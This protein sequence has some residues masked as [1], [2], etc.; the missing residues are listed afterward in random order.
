MSL[1]GQTPPVAAQAEAEEKQEHQKGVLAPD[2]WPDI[3]SIE[4]ETEA[5]EEEEWGPPSPDMLPDIGPITIE[6]DEPLDNF[7]VE[8]QQRLLTEPLYSSWSGPEDG[9]PFLVAANVGVFMSVFEPPVAPDVLL[10]MDVETPT[11]FA[12]KRNRTYFGWEFGKPPEVVIDIVTNCE[13]HAIEQKIQRYAWMK[14]DYA[15]VYDPFLCLQGDV[16]S[17]YEYV[18]LSYTRIE[19]TWLISA[20]LGLTLWNGVFEGI[21]GTWL[22]WCDSNGNVIP[23][24]AE[25]AQQE[26]VLRESLE[27]QLHAVSEQNEQLLAKLREQK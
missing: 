25:V 1:S 13:K 9:R 8:K 6:N 22:R 18:L 3:D 12:E 15:V 23:T 21:E 10:S 24:G 4:T 7:L 26:R 27:A 5:E 20:E 14:I 11:S 16:L 19:E 17:V 2:E